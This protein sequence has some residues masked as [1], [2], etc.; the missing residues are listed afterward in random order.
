MGS[1]SS[2]SPSR[3]SSNPT[4]TNRAAT[5]G[6]A[7]RRTH[8]A[9]AWVL[10]HD[11]G[12]RPW[13]ICVNG[14]RTGSPLADFWSFDARRLHHEYGLN[15]A[16][17]V[18]PLHGP[19]ARRS[20]R[21]PR[22]ALGSDEPDLHRRPGPVGHPPTQG[23]DPGP[24]QPD[25]GG[26]HAA[27][28]SAAIS[29]PSPP[30]YEDD[31]ACAIAG[32]P[33]PDLIRGQRR[34]AEP[35]LPPWYE[36]WGLSWRSLERAN[37]VVSPL[38]V[39]PLIA[40]E[41]RFIYAGLA[42]RWVRPGNVKTLWEHWD[43]PEILWY[44]GSHLSFP[45][46]PSV[47]RFVR[48]ALADTVGIRRVRPFGIGPSPPPV[49]LNTRC[50]GGRHAPCP[51]T[52]VATTGGIGVK[53]L[54]GLDAGFLSMETSSSYGHVSSLVIYRP[55]ADDPDFNAYDAFRSQLSRR[56]H[57]LEPLRRK[58]AEVPLGIDHPYWVNDRDFDL[59]FHVRHLGLAR[60]RA[61]ANSS[62][63]R[64]PASSADPLD[65]RRPLWEVYVIEGLEDGTF[66]V[67]TKV[68]HA[69]VDGASG[70]EMLMMIL[71]QDPAGD[72]VPRR[73][74][75]LDTRRGAHRAAAA[76]T[77]ARQLRHRHTGPGRP[78]A[79]PHGPTVRR[80]EPGPWCVDHDRTGQAPVA[81][82]AGRAHV[83]RT[84]RA[85]SNGIR[86]FA[87]PTP[88][89]KAIGPHRKFSMASSELSDIKE[90]KDALG[91]TVNDIVMAVC[92]GALRRYLL[93][94]DA[95]PEE[96]L[97][98]MVPV[99]IRTGDE[100]DIW[101]NRVSSLFVD[102]P[103]HLDDPVDRVA[104]VHQSMQRAKEQ[105]DLVPAE[106]LVDVA[107]LAM[108]G[109]L[110]QVSRLAT[111]THLA[112][113]AGLRR[114]TSSSPTCPGP[115][116]PLYMGGAEML[117]FF[118]VSTVAEGRRASTSRC[119]ATATPSTSD[120]IACRDLMPDLDDRARPPPRAE[121]RGPRQG[122]GQA[123][124]EGEQDE[125]E[126]SPSPNGLDPRRPER[127]PIRSALGK[128]THRGRK[129]AFE[130]LLEGQLMDAASR[131]SRR[132]WRTSG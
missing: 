115:R 81:V 67:L 120:L 43:E 103:T 23:V 32:V 106:S 79:T 101:T 2:T 98:A 131:S 48:A 125:E 58:L 62:R 17:P 118:P 69:T 25:V 42:D 33:E 63:P 109:I 59:D 119:R 5:G 78:R 96:P 18:Q 102:I 47:R 24:Q 37:R 95:L 38:R 129:C 130:S 93:D 66:G 91:A 87:P 121:I 7:T 82:V 54:T 76:R 39:E 122:V 116:V 126:A 19:R 14:Y 21:R 112:D 29:P 97:R 16:F 61:P 110:A 73:R 41:R 100:A 44:E 6:W 128:T 94:H 20:L 50:R 132:R 90:I 104:A 77:G 60:A 117:H 89:N 92:A 127:R 34:N 85:E 105:F 84:Q 124:E 74:R 55:P 26:H 36:Q 57:L 4:P 40:R 15:L 64:S 30:S 65:R 3:A 49:R 27:S 123:G 86:V 11:D 71:D 56:L 9:H 99:S 75:L 114:S 12:P 107:N 88:F 35:L 31:L 45:I 28:R 51:Y 1:S 111:S 68:H 108:P 10:R 113:R 13:L 22:P 72:D 46:E 83:V 53:Q 70:V 80:G 52:R 8:T